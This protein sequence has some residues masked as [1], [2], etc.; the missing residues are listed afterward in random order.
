MNT[1]GTC[2]AEDDVAKEEGMPARWLKRARRTDRLQAA[3][4]L[5]IAAEPLRQ[6]HFSSMAAASDV[7]NL[8]VDA[9]VASETHVLPACCA[10]G[11]AIP[12][13][14]SCFQAAAG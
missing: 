12:S 4:L 10:P 6:A 9:E 11:L 13:C 8:H 2:G 3:L 1:L 7:T 14:P 5:K